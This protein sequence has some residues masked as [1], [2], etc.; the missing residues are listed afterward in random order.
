VEIGTLCFW[1]ISPAKK[2]TQSVAEGIPT[3]TVGTRTR[4][5]YIPVG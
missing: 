4:E 1:G 3:E 2:T 5:A